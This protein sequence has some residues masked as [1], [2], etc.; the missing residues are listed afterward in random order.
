MKY[1]AAEAGGID[2]LESIQHISCKEYLAHIESK[3]EDEIRKRV[4]QKNI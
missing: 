2:K 4:A 3:I 1:Y